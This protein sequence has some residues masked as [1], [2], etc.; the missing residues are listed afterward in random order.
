VQLDAI[1]R[2]KQAVSD[3]TTSILAGLATRQANEQTAYQADVDRIN[4][5]FTAAQTR[6]A[7]QRTAEDRALAERR[8]G[9]DIDLAAHRLRQDTKL[10]ED[11][12]RIGDRR[13]SEDDAITTRRT[14][15][16]R[17]LAE[18]R[19][20]DDRDRLDTRGKEDVKAQEAAN[21]VAAQRIT[22]DRA[23]ADRRLAEDRSRSDYRTAEDLKLS[24]QQ[25]AVQ[26]QLDAEKRA[27]EAHYNGPLGVITT[28]Q[29]AMEAAKEAYRLRKEHAELQFSAERAALELVYRSPDKHGLLDLQDEA[30]KNNALRLSD[31]LGAISAWKEQAGKFID[32]NKGKWQSLAGAIEAVNSAIKGLPTTVPTP[33]PAPGGGTSPTSPGPGLGDQP[34]GDPSSPPPVSGP[35]G[36]GSGYTGPYRTTFGFA[37]PYNGPFEGGAAWE[38][39]PPVH[40]G[41]DLAANGPDNGFGTVYGAFQSGQV[42]TTYDP[43]GGNGIFVKTD[44]GLWNYYGHNKEYVKTSGHV[45]KGEPL[46]VIGRS[47]LEGPGPR[48]QTHLHYEVRKA[49]GGDPISQLID[50]RPYMHASG[51]L[52]REP[53]ATFGLRSGEH[54]MIGEAGAERLLGVADTQRFDA[55]RGIL[56]PVPINLPAGLS[57][58]SRAA[59]AALAASVAGAGAD[60]ERQPITFM[61]GNTTLGKVVVKGLKL[62]V[63]RGLTPG[64]V[65]WTL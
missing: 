47:G 14:N 4:T 32:E 62:E 15:E 53:T 11:K 59:G 65:G 30:A 28:I 10:A 2:R 50:P 61:I 38:G 40:R 6:I 1:A 29:K 60:L 26:V 24:A 44:A 35:G 8:L 56:P 64:D 58:Y 17:D 49:Q 37:Q 57:P 52:F 45:G 36:A 7:D 16:D 25:A 33:S 5:R 54:G 13:K 3:E 21:R 48:I 46:G 20:R 42:S 18:R 9:E 19:L 39:G 55:S 43:A 27:T 23:L 12:I 63:E 22:E 31:Q 51:Y 34:G 41:I